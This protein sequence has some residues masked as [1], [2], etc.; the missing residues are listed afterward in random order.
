MT[1]LHQLKCVACRGG[2]PVLNDSEIADL[3]PHI[4]EWQ[5]VEV[6][7]VKRLER[8][9]RMK[10]FIEAIAFTNK[11]GLISEK[12]DHHPLIVTEYGK[13]TV[14][15]WTHKIK[16]L[17]QNDFIMAAKTDKLV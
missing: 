1:D 16:G 7:D 15:W 5:V 11:I 13:V 3:I 10:D 17:H 6:N 14:A 9:F 4:P 8:E 2:E 12:E